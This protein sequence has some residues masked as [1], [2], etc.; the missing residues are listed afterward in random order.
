MKTKELLSEI[1]QL[2]RNEKLKILQFLSDD[3]STDI[4]K[5]FEGRKLFRVSPRIR[6]TKAAIIQL[7][8][9]R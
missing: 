1:Q 8:M 4:E 9:L 2:N 5:H 7:E 3:L 6:A